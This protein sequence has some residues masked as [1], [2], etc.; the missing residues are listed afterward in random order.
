MPELR[1]EKDSQVSTG[2][3]A[4][5]L[6]FLKDV[7]LSAGYREC[8]TLVNVGISVFKVN[9]SASER[10]TPFDVMLFVGFPAQQLLWSIWSPG[11]P[12][13]GGTSERI[14]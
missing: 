12:F 7:L 6:L 1:I 2:S 11:R 3:M 5:F 9:P 13:V 14:G 10:S 4:E 8:L